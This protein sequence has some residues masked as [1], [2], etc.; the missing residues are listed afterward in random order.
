MGASQA[1]DAG[2]AV[3]GYSGAESGETAILHQPAYPIR[4]QVTASASGSDAVQALRR[5]EIAS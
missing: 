5:A 4:I 3:R 1:S 2:D